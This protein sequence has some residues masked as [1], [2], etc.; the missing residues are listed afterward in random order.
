MGKKAGISLASTALMFMLLSTVLYAIMLDYLN[1]PPTGNI[2]EGL[3]AGI[4]L[5][6]GLAAFAL[7]SILYLVSFL[8]SRRVESMAIGALFTGGGILGLI[9]F[10]ALLALLL[11]NGLRGPPAEQAIF[12]A[13]ALI[14]AIV[15]LSLVLAGRKV[16]KPSIS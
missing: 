5:L 1:R 9:D 11:Q 3:G 6:M 13:I 14:H 2:L 10:L 8:V 16:A 4:A 12:L 7:S 15:G